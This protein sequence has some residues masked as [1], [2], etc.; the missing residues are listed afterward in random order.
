MISSLT[1]VSSVQSNNFWIIIINAC[2]TQIIHSE[3]RCTEWYA[4]NTMSPVWNFS[5]RNNPS[6]YQ[7]QQVLSVDKYR[8]YIDP[9]RWISIRFAC[10]PP[11]L[12]FQT[13]RNH[14]CSSSSFRICLPAA[15]PANLSLHT[16]HIS[17]SGLRL[18]TPRM[19]G[20]SSG[21]SRG[22]CYHSRCKVIIRYATKKIN[23]M[24]ISRQTWDQFG[25]DGRWGVGG[26]FLRCTFRDAEL[27]EATSFTSCISS[28]RI[29]SHSSGWRMWLSCM[30]QTQWHWNFK[31]NSL[32]FWFYS[33]EPLRIIE[34]KHLWGMLL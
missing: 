3:S 24:N 10:H 7:E 20:W 26:L 25:T 34:L 31:Q 16:C 32:T 21:T 17:S 9:K 11:R 18:S 14:I 23:S 33:C 29:L 5:N 15:R 13:H 27:L 22:P 4:V 28:F 8:T 1:K 12:H 6:P 30:V 19:H 2:K